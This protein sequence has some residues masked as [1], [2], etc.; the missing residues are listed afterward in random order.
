MR[1]LYTAISYPDVSTDA[2][3]YTD[4][5]R[6][7]AG[8]GAEVRVIAPATGASTQVTEE[9]G[10]PVLRV[11]SGPLVNTGL[12]S[13]G[14]NTLLLNRRYTRAFRRYWP[15]WRM[16][17]ILTS[18]PPITLSPL[19]HTLQKQFGARVYLMLRDIFPQNAR[20]LGIIKNPLLLAFFRRR[21]CHLYQISDIIGCM[22]PGNIAFLHRRYPRTQDKLTYFPNW[23]EPTPQSCGSHDAGFRQRNGL[24]GKFI[25][26]FGGNFGR[27]QQMDFLLE[28]AGRVRHVPDVVFVL[29]GRGT[30]KVHIENLVKRRDLNNVMIYDRLPRDEYLALSREAD[31]GLVNL[32]QQFTIPNIPSRTLAYWDASLP[33][34][35]ATD[36]YTDLDE[37]FLRKFNAGLGAKTGNIDDYYTKFMTLYLDPQL[38]KTLGENGRKAVDMEFSTQAAVCRLIEQIEAHS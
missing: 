33:V 31:I 28:L 14:F 10:I 24:A 29:I 11:R 23:L 22:S 16:D 18:T 1:F 37:N 36:A 30:E 34:L 3:M 21:E 7:L 9:G 6:A 13:K 19:L 20:D 25:A 5:I 27:P 8:S 2:N 38:R 35:A 4:L 17:W 26:L 12:L 15:D 32:S